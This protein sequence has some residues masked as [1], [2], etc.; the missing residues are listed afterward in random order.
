MFKGNKRIAY[1]VIYAIIV[2][3]IIMTFNYAKVEMTTQTIPYSQ[4]KT[5][6]VANEVQSVVVEGNE[7][8]VT[9]KKGTKDA[10]KTLYVTRMND[11]ELV[12][13]LEKAGVQFEAKIPQSYPM[14]DLLLS[15]VLPFAF[16][17]IIG[18]FMF[19]RIDKRMG[20][21][22]MSFGK[23]NAKVYAEAETGVTFD[24]VAGQDEA[25]E[26]LK[27][28]VDFLHDT[29]RYVSIGAKL[30]KGALLVGPPGTGKT[31]LAKA[32]AGEAKVP[33]FS[34]AGSDF[35]EMFVGMGAARVRDLFKQAEEKAP[36]IVFI[37]EIDAIGK[38]R[39]GSIQGNDEREQTLNQLLTEMDGFDSSKG[40]VIL[41]ATNRPEVL[42]KA[43]LRPGRFDRRVIVDRPDLI[44]REAILKVHAKDVKMS[45]E[46]S[47]EAIAKATPGAVGA[48]LAN[49]V[50]EAALRAVKR[51]RKLVVQED[52]EEAVEIII[53]GKEKKDRIM[54]SKE[55][56]TVAY[57]E[58]GHALVAALLNNT[59]PVHKITI[60]PRTMGALGYTM[61]LPEEE[62]YLLTKEEMLEQIAVM[63]GGRAAEEVE[64]GRITT[65]ASN[66]IERATQSARNM[67]TLYGMS[68]R[69]D[70][71]A[72][73]SA[74]N[75][76]L[77][78]RNVMN[79]S[80]ET[81]TIVDEE[82]LKIIKTSHQ[83]AIDIL[84]TN[85]DLLD[86]IS[87]V[88]L[89]KE[90]IMGDEFMALVYEKY[91][92]KK[93]K[94][95]ALKKEKEELKKAAK[96]KRYEMEEARKEKEKELIAATNE[97]AKAM[98]QEYDL[99]TQ[100]PE[101][102][103]K[104]EELLE[105][106]EKQIAAEKPKILELQKEELNLEKEVIEKEEKIKEIDEELKKEYPQEEKK[107]EAPE[108]K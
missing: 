28:I 74:S 102:I 38:S 16:L 62:K 27:E 80:N 106:V 8:Q 2:L 101:E 84:N 21:G 79:C 85:K 41:A 82:V 49:I 22:V 69:F 37:D 7:I 9:P 88:L 65:G 76:Y 91:P 71:M 83:M 100:S 53:A 26:S 42:D 24:D 68:D 46:V 17:M 13:S 25:K 81:A 66:D 99:L 14:A 104:N 77:D 107:P 105:E 45:K 11:P 51:N 40:V 44:G 108:D 61:Q 48:D 43:L 6:L 103:G 35:V 23:N 20:G 94:M 54:T 30:P 31:L 96:A 52:L 98:E 72:L 75:R 63:F 4:F 90:T 15:Y 95:E 93:E 34:L 97:E 1:A 89:E 57:H 5:M 60:V 67:V 18:K 86:K 73:E 55:K 32:V 19:G 47:L 3:G 36:C 59:D 87:A 64:F 92:E 56:R 39:E 58:V 29:E 10:G 33:F 70:M 12:P 78:G 50:N